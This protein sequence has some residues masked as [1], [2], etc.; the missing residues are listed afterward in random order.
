MNAHTG[1][2]KE[3]MPNADQAEHALL[4]TLFLDNSLWWSLSFLKAEHFAEQF[5]GA[6]FSAIGRMVA[7]SRP[8]N[9]ITLRPH[10]QG[11]NASQLLASMAA[12]AVPASMARGL[13]LQ[14]VET[15]QQRVGATLSEEGAALFRSMPADMTPSK[16]AAGMIEDLTAIQD[17]TDFGATAGA[18][19]DVVAKIKENHLARKIRATVPL[20]LPQL[21]EVMSGDLEAG[22][23]YGLLSSSGEG[24]TSLLLQIVDHAAAAGHP[25][26]VF[27]YDQS[28]AQCIDQIASQRT[29][30]ENTRIR[31]LTL[32]SAE[33]ERY[34]QALD[35]LQHLPLEV[36]KCSS[37]DDGS[38]QI[39][40]YA[41]KFLKANRSDKPAMVVLDHVR[42]VKP[43]RDNDHE[44]RIAAEVN[45]VCKDVAGAHECV[46]LN[47]NQRN[48]FG[49]RR[50]NPR[51]V[52]ADV[53]GGE[54]GV[55]DYD[56][57]FY[58]YRASKY[59]K[60]QLATADDAKDEDRINARFIREKWEDDQAEIGV[61]KSRFGDPTR[62]FRVRFEAEFT[63]YTSMR[64]AQV[65][66]LFGGGL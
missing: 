36:R 50:K 28:A 46:W 31:N 27:S 64:S 47:L 41:R 37:R 19:K 29:G 63:R 54:Q 8:A 45:A 10:I 14:V 48:S 58:L 25:V 6:V 32:M 52:G 34:Y 13:A 43:R 59:W 4:G 62:R 1:T 24:K 18:V 22:N 51:P 65:P 17:A 5:N 66:E 30:I 15:W 49:M 23:L 35:A 40:A 26:L 57:I 42:K 9:P 61:L 55:E 44:G 56:G 38:T 33:A 2:F 7:E 53:F 12:N 20:V 16:I 11:D 21:R 39:A 3:P 60:A